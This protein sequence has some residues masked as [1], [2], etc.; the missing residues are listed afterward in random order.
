MASE[1][2]EN[3]KAFNY[4]VLSIL[5]RL[6]DAFPER[7]DFKALRF[8]VETVV[9]EGPESEQSKYARYFTDTMEW[10]EEEGFIKW[11]GESM[12]GNYHK[13]TLTMKGLTVL[14]YL[15]SSVAEEKKEQLIDRAKRVLGKGLEGAASDVV[16]SL[17]ARSFYLLRVLAVARTPL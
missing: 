11:V 6:Y 17:V 13:V 14:G 1:E 12:G 8:I 4:L 9:K 7:I 15:P 16:K 3:I 5:N 10:L 2:P